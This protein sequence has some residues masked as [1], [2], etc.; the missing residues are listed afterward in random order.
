MKKVLKR[1]V[2]IVMLLTMLFSIF[3][4]IANATEISSAYLTN[5]GDCGR[6]LQYWK[7]EIGDW[8][9]IITTFVAYNENGV[10]YPAYCLDKDASGVG[11]QGDYTV[12][13][14]RVLDDDRIWRVIINGYP[15]QSPS[16]MG[17]ENEDDAFVATKQAVY[18]ILY[19]WDAEAR[20]NGGD[21]RGV[22]IKNALVNLVN[23]GRYGTQTRANTD[24]N[25]N[26]DGE[27]FEDGDYYSQKYTVNSPV[28]TAQYTITA[29]A[30]LPEGS[31]ITDLSNNVKST[32][33]GSEQFKVKVPKSQLGKDVNGTIELKAKCKTYPVFYGETSIPGTQDYAVTFDAYG[34]I[35][36]QATLNVKTNTGKIQ[37]NKTDDETSEPIEGVTFGLYL[38]ETEIGQATTDE[39]GIATFENLYQD[40]YVLKELETNENYVLNKSDFKVNVNY[41]KTTKAN[42]E[43]EHKKGNL[44]IYK[45]DKD[46]IARGIGGVEFK[47]Y[48]YEFDKII[49]TYYT[50]EDGQIT[51]EDLRI[52]D[53]KVIETKTNKYYNLSPD[54]EINID[55]GKTTKATVLNEKKK[56]QIEVIKT[57]GETQVPLEG[58]VFIIEDSKGNI[59]DKITTNS[60]GK[61]TSKKLGIDETYTVYEEKT[62]IGYILSNEKQTVTLTEDQI[63]TLKFDNYKNKVEEIIENI[64]KSVPN[65]GDNRAIVLATGILIISA[66]GIGT[67]TALKLRK[68]S[69]R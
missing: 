14:N 37:I 3:S 58:V 1:S 54:T 29:T 36:G 63:T 19:G 22:A 6:H 64:E 48:S 57:D 52:G 40:N 51:I 53:Y 59:V 35:A 16:A 30:N 68:K 38:N 20:Y 39:N 56:G 42:L 13:I 32:F 34:D 2:A 17:V 8:S 65:T 47:L 7:D 62:L 21:D 25:I 4:N 43:N 46:N 67:I 49:G 26:Q 28:D 31:I 12:N 33:A 44:Q 15:Y 5:C 9:Y 27:F 55:W 11:E 18:C 50:N 23:I 69:N 66:L 10:Q 61:A 41:N 24:I 45:V 60:E